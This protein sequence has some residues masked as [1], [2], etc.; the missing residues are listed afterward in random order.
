MKQ[1]LHHTTDTAL[2]FSSLIGGVAVTGEYFC[3]RTNEL[4]TYLVPLLSLKAK[5]SLEWKGKSFEVFPSNSYSIFQFVYLSNSHV[6]TQL[7]YIYDGV[8]EQATET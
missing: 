1:C 7:F 4:S 3:A 8:L 5:L 2:S 6:E